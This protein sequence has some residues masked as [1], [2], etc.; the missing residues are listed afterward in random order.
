MAFS[1]TKMLSRFDNGIH[2]RVLLKGV[3][4]ALVI[5]FGVKMYEILKDLESDLLKH[6]DIPINYHKVVTHILHFLSIFAAEILLVYLLTIIFQ[7][8]F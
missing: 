3:E 6:S 2:L 5:I 4:A 7:T 1:L 8:E